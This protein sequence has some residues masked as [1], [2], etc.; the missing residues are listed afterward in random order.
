MTGAERRAALA[1]SRI[2]LIVGEASC[3]G[4]WETATRRA[5]EAGVI[6][7]VQLREKEVDDREFV[8]RAHRLVEI[9][10]PAGLLVLV[11][12]R[13]AL[14][15]EADADGAHVGEDDLPAREAR[16]LLGPERLLGVS[17][18]DAAEVAAAA[19]LGAD[20]AGLGPCF[21]TTTKRLSR[22]P[23]GPALVA[24]CVARTTLPLFPIGGVTPE[25]VSSLVAAGA[26]RVAVGSGILG[27]EDPAAA[28]RA[29]AAALPPLPS[30]RR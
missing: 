7:M 15:L 26:R 30:P 23:Q 16:G 17:T 9:A 25:N 20:Y 19:G 14:A 13:V 6:G 11:N 4:P 27:A 2:C 10:R 24:A 21:S 28:A 3:R 22:A 1:A 5:V 8:R 18:H 29:I 12:D